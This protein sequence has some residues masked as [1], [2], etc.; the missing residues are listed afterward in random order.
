MLVLDEADR[1][2]TRSPRRTGSHAYSMRRRARLPS[3]V[4]L[5]LFAVA[6][7]AAFSKQPT[8]PEAS[9]EEAATVIERTVIEGETPV[10]VNDRPG[11]KVRSPEVAMAVMGRQARIAI[12]MEFKRKGYVGECAR[13]LLKYVENPECRKDSRLHGRVANLIMSENAD[14]WRIYEELAKL[15]RQSGSGRK[16]IQAAF[17][18]ARIDLARPGDMIQLSTGASWTKKAGDQSEGE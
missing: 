18:K 13:S 1:T 9:I 15:N 17:H 2:V 14:R 6:G 8:M 10:V 11:F 12:V 4:Y 3:T 16:R 7:C 5:L